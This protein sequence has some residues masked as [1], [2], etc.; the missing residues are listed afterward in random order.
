V[1]PRKGKARRSHEPAPAGILGGKLGATSGWDTKFTQAWLEEHDLP[2]LR[3]LVQKH[4]LNE[5]DLFEAQDAELKDEGI[6]ADERARHAVLIANPD[7]ARWRPDET[8]GWLCFHA[9]PMAA[10]MFKKHNLDGTDLL[11]AHDVDLDTGGVPPP[12]RA[13][14]RKLVQAGPGWTIDA[15]VEWL[16]DHNLTA[17]A[18]GMKE[19]AAVGTELFEVDDDILA[20]FNVSPPERVRFWAAMKKLRSDA[21]D[22]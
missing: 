12:E 6:G 2:Q 21:S 17:S 22:K 18:V 5:L 13:K 7:C 3:A 10:E 11:E 1:A 9:L 14:I 20:S 8:V 4:Q 19:F 16:E 15:V